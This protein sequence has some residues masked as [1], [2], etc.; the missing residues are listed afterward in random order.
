MPYPYPVLF[1]IG[2]L[3]VYTFGFFMLIGFILALWLALRRKGKV[4]EEHIYNVA[5]ISLLAGIIGSRIAFFILSPQYL[6]SFFDFIAI[7]Q[8][9]MSFFGG[10]VFALVLVY[11]YARKNKLDYWNILD[12]FAP[13]LAL[14]IALTRIGAFI[15]G[16]NPGLP[17]EL[18]WAIILNGIPTHPA[19]L[20]HALANFAIFFILIFASKKLRKHFLPGYLFIFFMLLFGVERFVN[21]FF[22]AYD[23]LI[24]IMLARTIW[25]LLII[26]SGYLL[27]FRKK[28]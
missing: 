25:P 17:S 3:N 6:H 1:K 8:G 14:A 7:W 28:K 19:A 10:F 18:P 26:I 24:S 4:H 22:R 16:V 9:G 20:Y 2:S 13:S 5:I 21:D 11:W 15:A 23:A 12:I 27:W